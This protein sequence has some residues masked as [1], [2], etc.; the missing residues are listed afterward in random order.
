MNNF[1]NLIGILIKV[2]DSYLVLDV[3][4][5]GKIKVFFD[6]VIDNNCLKINSITKIEGRLSFFN[7]PFPV[8]I[9]NKIYQKDNN[10]L[11]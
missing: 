1:V 9:A 4:N 11:S 3:E 7:F 10:N 5:L 2:N 8:V 6:E